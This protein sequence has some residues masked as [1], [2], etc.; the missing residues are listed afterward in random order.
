MYLSIYLFICVY[1]FLFICL[2]VYLSIYLC[3]SVCRPIYLCLS[4]YLHVHLYINICTLFDL[5]ILFLYFCVIF[6]ALCLQA[7]KFGKVNLV[8][9]KMDKYDRKS[10][11]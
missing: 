7:E 6:T 8:F 2:S 1:L 3:L 5:S 9:P 10:C 4:V 11:D